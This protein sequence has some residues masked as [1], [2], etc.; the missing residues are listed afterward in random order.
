MSPIEVRSE[1]SIFKQSLSNVTGAIVNGNITINM[2]YFQRADMY[3]GTTF[4]FND[5][6]RSSFA[7]PLLLGY[8]NFH[9][10]KFFFKEILSIKNSRAL[11]SEIQI[12]RQFYSFVFFPY[13]FRKYFGIS[14]VNTYQPS[15]RYYESHYKG[16]CNTIIIILQLAD[17]SFKY[18]ENRDGSVDKTKTDFYIHLVHPDQNIVLEADEVLKLIDLNIEELDD[19]FKEF[20]VLDTQ[21]STFTV[22]ATFATKGRE[23]TKNL[24][25]VY[26]IG[27][28]LFLA[29][30]LLVVISICF[31]QR[32]KYQRQLKAATTNAYGSYVNFACNDFPPSPPSSDC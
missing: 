16:W 3:L 30:L 21:K 9:M 26:A 27:T 23:E 20:N 31:A 25:L 6:R 7:G 12:L 32:S 18:H 1:I 19:L 5:D 28:A 11:Y 22:G 10:S 24:F 13:I 14:F 2:H 8:K 4:S 17:A 15:D 29:L